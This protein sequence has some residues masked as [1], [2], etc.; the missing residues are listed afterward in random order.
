MTEFFF[1]Q[2]PEF[3]KTSKT[4]NSPNRLNQRNRVLI[5]NNLNIIKDKKILDIASHDGRWSFSA[6]KHG[7]KFVLGIEGREELVENAN[8]T[9]LKYDI[10]KE[11]YQFT[12]GDIHKEIKKLDPGSFDTIF[13]FGFFYHTINHFQLLSEIKRLNP[14]NLI[15]DTSVVKSSQ[16]VIKVANENSSREGAAI[17]TEID[18]HEQVVIGVPSVPAITLMLESLGYKVQQSDWESFGITNWQDIQDYSTKH[19]KFRNKVG[20]AI[21]KI[22]HPSI[23][24][25]KR[26]TLVAERK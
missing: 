14:K 21:K 16:P 17:R 7:A 3:F 11:K 12:A 5:E 18:N 4:A 6:L 19:I 26:V 23:I 15:M 20:W 2:Y 24:G 13:C 25:G 8:K 22:Q 9:M 1:D 10:P